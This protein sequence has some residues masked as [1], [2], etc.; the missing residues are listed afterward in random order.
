ML[1]ARKPWRSQTRQPGNRRL[2]L[3]GRVLRAGS[4][5]F[6]PATA[7]CG[8]KK[9]IAEDN[10]PSLSICEAI[11][12]PFPQNAACVALSTSESGGTDRFVCRSVPART[13]DESVRERP[14][15]RQSLRKHQSK[16]ENRLLRETRE[17]STASNRSCFQPGRAGADSHE[18]S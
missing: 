12:Y 9:V 17:R 15:I 4:E 14:S 16:S 7:G 5:G 13:Y 3:G 6:Y 1:V 2:P 18:W 10:L 8:E 11:A